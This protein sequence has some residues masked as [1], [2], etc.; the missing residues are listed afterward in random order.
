MSTIIS[1]S[2]K[3]FTA[4]A[5]TQETKSSIA[6]TI[7][8]TAITYMEDENYSRAAQAFKASLVYDPE[9]TDAYNYMASAYLQLGNNREAITAYKNSLKLDNSQAETHVNLGTV[10]ESENMTSEAEKEY[11]AAIQADSTEVLAPYT[12]G[13]FLLNNNRAS[14]SITQFNRASK[15]EP[16][17]G[18]INYALGKAYNQLGRY[19]EAVTQLQ[20]AIYLKGSDFYAA[21]YEL[22]I[23]CVGLGEKESVQSIIDFL[24]DADTSETTSYADIL[25]EDIRQPQI[26]DTVDSGT[27]FLKALGASTP[28][29]FL[30]ISLAAPNSSKDFTVQFQFDTEMDVS[31]VMDET[32]WSIRKANGIQEGL[33]NNGIYSSNRNDA[34]FSPIPK[35]VIY[36]PVTLRATVT[37]S[38]SQNANGN[39]TI[40]PS[41]LVFKFMGKDVSGKEMDTTADEYEYF[42]GGV[43]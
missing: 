20:K 9:S 23:S 21:Q 17:D 16:D 22:G 1:A 43:F 15:L 29:Y 13:L 36:D 41:H 38:V 8:S 18:N 3:I 32:K 35:M 39:A 34:L 40:D 25:E 2:D 26:L 4:L 33:Y 28:L 11:K 12:Y 30:D 24:N 14:E 31:S 19:S 27:T 5:S 7:L 37:F 6:T 42:A 10:Y